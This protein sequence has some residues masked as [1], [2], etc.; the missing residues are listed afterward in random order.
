MNW[1]SLLSR[2]RWCAPGEWRARDDSSV[3]KQFHRDYDRIIFSDAFRRL[4]SKTQVHPLSNNDQVRTRLSHSLEVSCVGR[5]FGMVAGEWLASQG[6]LPAGLHPDDLGTVVQAAA[7]AHDI[8][9]PPFGHAGEDAIRFFFRSPRGRARTQPLAQVLRDELESF[10]GNAQGLRVLTQMDP[11]RDA[12]GMRLSAASL[13]TFVKYPWTRDAAASGKYGVNHSEWAIFSEAAEHLGMVR[14][15]ANRFARHPLVYLVE[16]ADDACYSV[17]DIEDAVEMGVIEFDQARS[18]LLPLIERAEHAALD[19]LAPH[20][21]LYRA[22]GILIDRLESQ[23]VA[24]L[25]RHYDAMLAG[26][27]VPDLLA[28]SPVGELKAFARANIYQSEVKQL[29][30]SNARE[31]LFNVL[32]LLTGALH[33]RYLAGRQRHGYSASARWVLTHLKRSLPAAE[34]PLYSQYQQALDYVS[35]MTDP[36]LLSFAKGLQERR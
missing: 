7:L 19:G 31:A 4:G 8:G 18:L 5:T 22:R 34:L 36:Y 13:G 6:E 10:E 25:A 32:D 21:F 3:R 29:T 11:H 12:G 24:A 26:Q 20:Q 23:M 27:P 14:Q 30:Q 16:A 15:S 2:H 28:D 17:I 35:G 9:N 33:E 1:E